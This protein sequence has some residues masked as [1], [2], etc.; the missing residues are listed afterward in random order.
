MQLFWFL[1]FFG[2]CL[3]TFLFVCF[4]HLKDKLWWVFT[5]ADVN[6]DYIYSSMTLVLRIIYKHTDSNIWAC[7]KICSACIMTQ[8][9]FADHSRTQNSKKL[10]NFWEDVFKK[11]PMNLISSFSD[12]TSVK[13][14]VITFFFPQKAIHAL[15]QISVPV[16]F[17]LL[18]LLEICVL[19]SLI[20]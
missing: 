6:F 8:K 13:S 3:F 17:C 9:R 11:S 20:V 18:P 1:F 5:S 2:F 4:I 7:R 19:N 14:M 15:L 16:K 10:N 12:V